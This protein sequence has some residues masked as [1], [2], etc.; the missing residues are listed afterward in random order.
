MTRNGGNMADP[1]SV[2][3]HLFTR[4]GGDDGEGRPI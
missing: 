1:G 2:A 3:Y 4:K